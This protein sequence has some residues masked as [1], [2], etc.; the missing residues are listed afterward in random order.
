[1]IIEERSIDAAPDDVASATADTAT[2]TYAPAGP[3]IRHCISGVAWSFDAY[4]I[5]ATPNLTVTDGTDV[6]FLLP[7]PYGGPGVIYFDPPKRG[8]ANTVLTVALGSGGA[9][10]VGVLNVLGHWV[11]SG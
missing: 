9:G 1:M 10:I 5:G 11:E 8:A 6:V 3:G 7:I 4:Q 2:V